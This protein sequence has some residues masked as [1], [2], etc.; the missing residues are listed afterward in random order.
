MSDF[1][2]QIEK[3]ALNA[4]KMQL[5]APNA[6]GKNAGMNIR[7]HNNNFRIQVY[8][9]DPNDPKQGAITAAM[10]PYVFSMMLTMIDEA[11]SAPGEYRNYID[12]MGFKFIGGKR[13]DKQEVL[14]RTV[15]GK[16]ADGIVYLSIVEGGRPNVK[17]PMLPSSWHILRGANGDVE[18]KATTSRMFAKGFVR[19]WTQLLQGLIAY[20]K[21]EEQKQGG[22]GGGFGGG[23]GGG[24]GFQRRGNGGG[25][26]GGGFGGGQGGGNSNASSGSS[27]ISDEDDIPW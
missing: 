15:I 7:L 1:K 9:N 16:D 5:Q 13:G 10:E 4:R 25:G 27:S 14:S 8:T 12:N 22:Q 3:N 6:A 26:N 20:F 2:P 19:I 23:Q 11:V 17:F 18:E 21:E 24:G